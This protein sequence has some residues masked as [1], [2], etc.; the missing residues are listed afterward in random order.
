M[1]VTGA[2]RR[3]AARFGLRGCTLHTLRHTTATWLLAGGVDVRATSSTLG[4]ADASTTLRI[5]AHVVSERQRATVDVI[6]NVLRS[7]ENALAR[8]LGRQPESERK[9]ARKLERFLVAPTG[10]EP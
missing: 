5:Y 2:F 4:H 8:H 3:A 10:I 6:G 1:A 9:N 7:P